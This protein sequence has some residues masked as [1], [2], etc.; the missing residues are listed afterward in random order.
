[1]KKLSKSDGCRPLSKEEVD[2][3][4]A[5]MKAS[6]KLMQETLASRKTRA[7]SVQHLPANQD[8]HPRT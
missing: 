3:L 1:M 8:V 5:D 7:S 4:R 2:A 6:S